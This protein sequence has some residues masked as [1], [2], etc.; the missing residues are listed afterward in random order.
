MLVE[1]FCSRI[2]SQTSL[3]IF[4]SIESFTSLKIPLKCHK[5]VT[6]E[7][8]CILANLHGD[9]GFSEV[10]YLFAIFCGE[11]IEVVSVI[12][13]EEWCNIGYFSPEKAIRAI[14]RL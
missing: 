8:L 2:S 10:F 4:F 5:H 1:R 7:I 3:V 13:I 14:K 6:G 12:H 11:E 9:M